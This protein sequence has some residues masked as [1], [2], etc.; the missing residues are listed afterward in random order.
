MIQLICRK[1]RLLTIPYRR[2]CAFL[3]KLPQRRCTLCDAHG[4]NNQNLCHPCA[5]ELPRNI[6]GC[7]GCGD[8]FVL[9]RTGLCEKCRKSS[10]LWKLCIIASNYEI[11][12]NYLV[13]RF[14]YAGDK[15]S[16][17]AMAEYMWQR[18][19]G[20][21]DDFEGAIFLA[22]PLHRKRLIERGFNQ[23]EFLAAELAKRCKGVLMTKV[24]VRTRPTCP[25][26][27]LTQRA[28][29]AN[30]KNAFTIRDLPDKCRVVL[31]DD[32]L[33]TGSTASECCRVLR[34]SGVDDLTLW[35]FARANAPIN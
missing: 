3:H 21:R 24:L 7:T 20:P 1:L 13:K 23:S 29:K 4:L 8:L 28:R 32:V 17:L 35:C 25:Q 12:A 14:K 30:I 19:E 10:P 15:A 26:A 6:N 31:V 18:A 5:T 16:G 33:T 11:P 34:R 9:K 22:V 2:A 27:G